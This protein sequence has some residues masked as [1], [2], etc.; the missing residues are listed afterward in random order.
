[1]AR[2]RLVRI[3]LVAIIAAPLGATC[4]WGAT[5]RDSNELQP[6][7]ILARLWSTVSVLWSA[8]GCN[9]DP[10][11]GCAAQEDAPAPPPAADEGCGL[12]P[13]GGC[14]PGS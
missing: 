2:S 4:A 12:D 1:M 5:H 10:H 6:L 9:L 11:G 13:H 3:L 7:D 14:A 8:S